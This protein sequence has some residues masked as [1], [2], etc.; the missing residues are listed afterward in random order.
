MNIRDLTW[1][2]DF[3]KILLGEENYEIDKKKAI[4]N[5]LLAKVKTNYAVNTGAG[6]VEQYKIVD[7]VSEMLLENTD[8]SNR[9]IMNSF[10]N[11]YKFLLQI[12]YPDVFT[13]DGTLNDNIHLQKNKIPVN[14]NSRRRY[15]PF[16]SDKNQFIDKKYIYYYKNNFPDLVVND[17]DTWVKFLIVNFDYFK[18]VHNYPE[19]Y[20][21][22]RLTHT[23][24][25]IDVVSKNTNSVRALR[26]YDYWDITLKSVK[27]SKATLLDWK[28][29]VDS[30]HL[31]NYVDK[32]YNVV[33]FWENHSKN[34]LIPE[35]WKD[36]NSFLSKVN[37]WIEDRGKQILN[38]I[39]SEQ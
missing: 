34:S 37:L 5:I 9:D 18:M 29:F 20:R 32:N 15:P 38:Q 22:A 36:V 6:H 10:W 4:K 25:N 35:T 11:T 24:G 13:P 39:G 23:I 3:K 33:M 8:Y 14:Q 1:N 21:F 30:H 17:G 28:S 12:E 26:D 2:F 27:E 16:D 19:L 31:N 7:D